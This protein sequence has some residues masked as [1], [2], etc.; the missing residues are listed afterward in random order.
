VLRLPGAAALLAVLFLVNFVGR[1][2]TPVLPL[3]LNQL[4]VPAGWLALSTGAVISAYSVAAAISAS[5]LGK[6]S[7]RHPPRALLAGSLLAG[8]LTVLPMALVAT[9]PPFLALGTLL[10]LASGGALTLCYTIGGLMVPPDHRALAFGF[11]SGAALFGGAIAPT[12]AGYVARF[13]LRTVYYLDA[14]IFLALAA[15]LVPGVVAARPRVAEP[16]AE[17]PAELR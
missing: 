2:L 1:S 17:R 14:A 15:A 16:S 6:A 5:T 11:F 9:Y 12:V 7:R 4:R 8:A 3:H 13:N 10:G